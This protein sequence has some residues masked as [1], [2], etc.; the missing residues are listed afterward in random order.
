MRMSRK[1]L[2]I[3]GGLLL[4][5]PAGSATGTTQ[6]EAPDF[7]VGDIQHVANAPGPFILS[8]SSEHERA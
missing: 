1:L 5:I 2:T 7:Q 8:A 6:D 3:A 4:A